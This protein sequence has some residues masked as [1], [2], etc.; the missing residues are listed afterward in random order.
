MS[1]E[2]VPLSHA[3]AAL[4]QLTQFRRALDAADVLVRALANAEQVGKELDAAIA[5]KRAEFE[6]SL[7]AERTASRQ[8]MAKNEAQMAANARA[9]AEQ[10]VGAARDEAAQIGQQLTAKRA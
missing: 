10:I 2:N 6:K 5:A 1:M 8:E 3:L 7:D 4:D 9:S